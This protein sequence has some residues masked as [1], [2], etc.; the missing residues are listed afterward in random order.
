MYGGLLCF[1]DGKAENPYY[2]LA[3]QKPSPLTEAFNHAYFLGII[4]SPGMQKLSAKAALATEQRIPGLGNGVLQDIL[5]HTGVHPLRLIGSL[6]GT[7]MEK[8]YQSVKTTLADMAAQGG[9]DAEKDLFGQPG[10]YV[11]RCSKL[12]VG[13]PCSICGNPIR[14]ASYMGGSVYFCEVCQPLPG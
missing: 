12:T 8:L 11:T 1:P 9:R 2:L 6:S 5:Y 3:R 10:G 7:E 13:S 4:A 14:K